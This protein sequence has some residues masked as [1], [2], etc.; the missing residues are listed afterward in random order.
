VYGQFTDRARTVMRLA[1]QEAQRFN[2]E[3][4]GTEHI[5]LGLARE[6]AGVATNVLKKRG[7]DLQR[8]RAEVEKIVCVGPDII[9]MGQLPHTP[10]ARKVIEYAIEEAQ[11]LNHKHFGTEYLLLGLCRENEGVAGQV[12]VN[13]DVKLEAVREE[14]K[15]VAQQNP[16]GQAWYDRLMGSNAKKWWQFWR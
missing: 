5:L 2:H 8:I 10:R 15:I 1:N 7:V 14:V 4:I 13:L 6:G 3:Y 9:T 12:L 11:S 16:V